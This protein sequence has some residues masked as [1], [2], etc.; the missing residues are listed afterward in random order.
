MVSLQEVSF[1]QL[2]SK[3]EAQITFFTLVVL[4]I[5]FI[6]ISAFTPVISTFTNFVTAN[7]DVSSNSRTIW[8]LIP[9]FILLAFIGTMFVFFGRRQ[10]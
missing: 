1:G 5:L 2:F 8:G 6:I 10:V 4:I 3:E 9:T 7:S